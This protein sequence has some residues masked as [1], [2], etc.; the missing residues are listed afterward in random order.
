MS[1]DMSQQTQASQELSRYSALPVTVISEPVNASRENKRPE[2][3]PSKKCDWKLS[4]Q[5][6]VDGKKQLVGIRKLRPEMNLAKLSER[7]GGFHTNSP[8]D[9]DSLCREFPQLTEVS[10]ISQA[11]AVFEEWNWAYIPIVDVTGKYTGHCASR[12]RLQDLLSGQARPVRIGGLATPLGVYM[13]SGLYSSGAGWPGLIATGAL[14]GVAAHL[15]DYW[16]ALVYSALVAVF[17]VVHHLNE[18]MHLTLETGLAL[19]SFMALIRLVPI[20]GL[21]AA[22]HM[23]INAIENDLPLLPPYVRSQPRE[24]ARCGTNLMVLLGGLELVGLFLYASWHDLNPLGRALYVSLGL[25]LVLK[26]WQKAGLWLQRNFTTKDPT[27]A[28]LESGIKAGQELL[29][30]YRANP[31]P[32]PS[33]WRRILGSGMIHMIIAFIFSAWA[34]GWILEFI[35]GAGGH[36][37]HWPLLEH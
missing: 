36:H 23:T 34:L 3:R 5:P 21:H 31:H 13:T 19:C 15:L 27:D 1:Q 2:Q 6:V 11:W 33:L 17:P 29:A 37:L 30:T 18:A 4:I 20:S 12:K 32:Y 26:N 22:E 28:Q 7:D 16:I 35:G 8:M 24:H 25:F 14:F 10:P 9:S